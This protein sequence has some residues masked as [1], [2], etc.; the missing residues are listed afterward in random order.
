MEDVARNMLIL[1]RHL[2]DYYKDT[3]GYDNILEIER[4]KEAGNF[5]NIRDELKEEI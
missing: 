5:D 4:A 1:V 2:I 3:R